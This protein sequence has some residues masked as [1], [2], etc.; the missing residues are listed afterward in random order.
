MTAGTMTEILQKI[1][2]E[3]GEK[4]RNKVQQKLH[5]VEV[6]DV[7]KLCR[8]IFD[9]SLNSKLAVAGEKRLCCGTLMK[10]RVELGR[11]H[12]ELSSQDDSSPAAQLAMPKQCFCMQCL[13]QGGNP[14]LGVRCGH[15]PHGSHGIIQGAAKAP[16]DF[17][18]SNASCARPARGRFASNKLPEA[19]SRASSAVHE[20]DLHFPMAPGAMLPE[21]F[22][23]KMEPQPLQKSYS[24]PLFSSSVAGMEVV[25]GNRRNTSST[26]EKRA[27]PRRR[28]NP[29]LDRV[30]EIG[31]MRR[32]DD[33]L[34]GLLR[35]A[36]EVI[37][38]VKTGKVQLGSATDQHLP[39]RPNVHP[40]PSPEQPP[41]SIWV[42]FQPASQEDRPK[43]PAF[44][45]LESKVLPKGPAFAPLESKVLPKGP[46]FAALESKVLQMNEMK[47]SDSLGASNS[48]DLCRME[49]RLAAE[50]AFE[51]DRTEVSFAATLMGVSIEGPSQ[52]Q[53]PVVRNGGKR[54]AP[55]W[56][57][58]KKQQILKFYGEDSELRRRE[59]LAQAL[60]GV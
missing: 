31:G 4:V 23:P 34:D 22:F 45:A 57:K 37:S 7:D 11:R 33:A 10:L 19:G 8:A 46:A 53:Q 1:R 36:G 48:D 60:R 18:L 15:H 12:R 20:G 27:P 21:H 55:G 40:G 30:P 59:L 9:G 56:K 39:S 54:E 52:W 16:L 50:S 17:G 5:K 13:Q 14:S 41:P 44:G 25:M 42:P 28:S 2:P 47:I 51:N 49:S 58:G 35:E 38:R 43:G 26:S 29:V 3:W 6:T 24:E 32:D